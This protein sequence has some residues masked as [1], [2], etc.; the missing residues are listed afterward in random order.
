MAIEQWR[1][2]NS[3]SMRW[4]GRHSP[5]KVRVRNSPTKVRVRNK[6]PLRGEC[7]LL[8]CIIEREREREREMA[9]TLECILRH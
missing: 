4:V 5:T 7:I 9:L 3:E 8:Y 2:N 6:R 1:L